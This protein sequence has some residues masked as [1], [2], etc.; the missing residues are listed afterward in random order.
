MSTLVLVAG[1]TEQNIF[2]T[3]K[4]CISVQSQMFSFD[5]SP[6]YDGKHCQVYQGHSGNNRITFA[7][8]GIMAKKKRTK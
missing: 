2:P 8:E 7:E 6:C 1:S 4:A 3:V 5:L